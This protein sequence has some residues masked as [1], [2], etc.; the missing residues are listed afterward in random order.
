MSYSNGDIA[1]IYGVSERTV[2][3]HINAFKKKGK[4]IKTS[5]G[6]F[7]NDQDFNTICILLGIKIEQKKEDSNFSLKSTNWM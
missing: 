2:S 7:Y 6:K 5:V 4:F 3:R 1:K